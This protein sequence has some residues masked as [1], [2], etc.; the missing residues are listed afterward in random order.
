MIPIGWGWI[1][2]RDGRVGAFWC[3]GYAQPFAKWKRAVIGLGY[4]VV[5]VRLAAPSP[6]R[7][8]PRRA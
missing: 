2:M 7:L 4:T 1:G 8:T 6:Q 5:R 3:R